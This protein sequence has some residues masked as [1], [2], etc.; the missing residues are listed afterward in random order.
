MTIALAGL[1]DDIGFVQLRSRCAE[2]MIESL[3]IVWD[4]VGA[5]IG[6]RPE[7][8][9]RRFVPVSPKP[10]WYVSAVTERC[11]APPGLPLRVDARV[12]AGLAS[13]RAR[14]RG[15][16]ACDL[17][18]APAMARRAGMSLH[19]RQ[20]IPRATRRRRTVPGPRQRVAN[21]GDDE[22]ADQP[23]LPETHPPLVS[24]PDGR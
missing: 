11:R 10:A 1:R 17:T 2:G 3:R 22:R 9:R 6:G 18:A 8:P 14:R 5:C 24:W 19:R 13:A 21:G 7:R 23:R 16:D 15:G 12:R 20:F 4:I